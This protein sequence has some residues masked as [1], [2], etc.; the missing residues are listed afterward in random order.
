[1]NPR[2]DHARNNTPFIWG[3]A[4]GMPGYATLA[5]VRYDRVFTDLDAIVEAYRKGRPLAEALFGPDVQ[6]GGPAWA[7]NSY[8]HV[9][10]LGAELYFPEGSEV[11][12]SREHMCASLDEGIA[13]LKKD[14]DFRNAGL[15]PQYLKLWE[16]LKRAF[17]EFN[18]RFT[19][20]KAEGP[21]TTAWILRGH[22]F[23]TDLYEQPEKAKEFLRLGV[24][25]ILKYRETERAVNGL[26]LFGESGAG[27]ADDVAAMIS[28]RMW[29][30][31]V[32]PNLER[33]YAAQTNGPRSAHIENLSVDHLRFLDELGVASYDPSVSGKL[34]PALIRANCSARFSW[35]LNATHYPDRSSDG[36]QRWVYEAVADGAPAV[37][38]NVDRSMCNEKSAEKINAFCRAGREVER[39]LNEGT[40]REEI[41]NLD[42]V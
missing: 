26:P 17:P 13:L 6:M 37:I 21:M 1:M 40:P 15:F 33:H 30:E 36:I 27:V 38:T 14:I 19:G 31:F 29:P 16:G 41:R 12:L 9:N 3:A 10:G 20:F 39:R 28:P 8:G 32:V 42:P 11:G 22:D 18:L 2:K 24:E 23:F 34:T 4:C 35:R 5:G 7:G 25:S